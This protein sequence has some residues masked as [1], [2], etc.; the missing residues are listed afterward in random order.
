MFNFNI[1]P[2]SPFYI[3]STKKIRTSG[4]ERNTRIAQEAEK[5]VERRIGKKLKRK[6]V[7]LA[8]WRVEGVS[9]G[10]PFL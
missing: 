4:M 2:Y 9:Y 5:C 6:K 1:C 3:S 10:E 8:R 7:G